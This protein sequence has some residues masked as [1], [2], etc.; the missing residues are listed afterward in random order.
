MRL[1]LY[2]LLSFA[3]M[4]IMTACGNESQKDDGPVAPASTVIDTPPMPD[5]A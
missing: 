5:H 3:I 4:I 2:I 1:Y